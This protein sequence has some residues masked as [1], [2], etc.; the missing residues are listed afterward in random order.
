MAQ[1]TTQLPLTQGTNK[2]YDIPAP[3]ST[4]GAVAGFATDVLNGYMKVRQDES[5]RKRSEAA[6]LEKKRNKD[7]TYAAVKG[8]GEAVDL[9][10][11]S[12]TA[13][14]SASAITAA[15]VPANVSETA[16]LTNGATDIALN[17]PKSTKVFEQPDINPAVTAAAQS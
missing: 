7:S 8:Y 15:V 1:L 3:P 5:E 12:V 10:N 2:I 16:G 6:A 11:R 9:T 14:A 4:L 17:A 13:Q